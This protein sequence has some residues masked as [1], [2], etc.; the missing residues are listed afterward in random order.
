MPI[1]NGLVSVIMPVFDGGELLP[2]ALQSVS[3]QDYPHLE[4]IAIDDG[5]R[6]NSVHILETFAASYKDRLKILTHPGKQQRGIAASY[7][8]GLEHCTGE[9]IAFL[10]QDDVWP[11]RKISEQIRIFTTI[12]QVGVV[13]SEVYSCNAEGR[14]ASKP[15]TSLV[16]RPPAA[17][18]FQ[19]FW[20]LLW[21]NYIYTFSNFMVRSCYIQPNDILA[22]PAGFQDWMLLLLLSQRCQFY[23]CHLTQTFWRQRPESYFA[24]ISQL[25]TFR[26]I[27]K[28][29]L[30]KAIE[31][32]LAESRSCSASPLYTGPGVALYWRGV[33]AL[34]SAMERTV[35]WMRHSLGEQWA[36]V[37]SDSSSLSRELGKPAPMHQAENTIRKELAITLEPKAT[38]PASLHNSMVQD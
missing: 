1:T 11:R 29:A 13:F 30:S 27:R 33:I 4:I 17:R 14:I 36:S 19:A 24:Q 16:N 22:E 32:L 25:P 34:F 2:L 9:Y 37:E 12:P 7:R 18:P 26:R 10:E 8:L 28:L 15:L 6:D 21:G 5:S 20:R 31:R 38:Q 35:S 23:C 3:R